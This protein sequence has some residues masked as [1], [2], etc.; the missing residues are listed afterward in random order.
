[1]P[2]TVVVA[3]QPA[4]HR[5]LYITLGAV[6]V[7]VVLVAAGFTVP[8]YLKARAS[9]GQSSLPSQQMANPAPAA[10][11]MAQPATTEINPTPTPAPA[12]EPAAATPAIDPAA[13]AKS[14]AAAKRKQEQA[15]TDSS[16]QSS[17]RRR[18][19]PSRSPSPRRRTSPPSRPSRSRT[20][21]GPT[22][23]P[24]RLS[25]SQPSHAKKFHVPTRPRPKRRH[26][27]RR[28][29]SRHR[30]AK[31]PTSPRRPKSR[32]RPAIHQASRRRSRKARK[33]HGP[34]SRR[35]TRGVHHRQGITSVLSQSP[36]ASA[37]KRINQ[38][39][40]RSCAA[41][42]VCTSVCW[43]HRSVTDGIFSA[44]VCFPRTSKPL[45]GPM[46]MPRE[47]LASRLGQGDRKCCLLIAIACC[48]NRRGEV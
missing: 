5:G 41:V 10:P 13:A 29:P 39:S 7:L 12:A 32:S 1:M 37:A 14:A 44:V 34:L 31:S 22:K 18:K 20:S 15:A 3:A 26:G 36:P 6:I 25:K 24:R 4:S 17:R 21:N 2:P 48:G 27:S 19:S 11:A 46:S 28:S 47:L 40:G 23:R 16:R 42:V 45:N 8:R 30:H 9:S 33:I 43:E 38:I 35:E